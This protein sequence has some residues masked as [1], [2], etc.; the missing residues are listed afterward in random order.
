MK[1]HFAEHLHENVYDSQIDDASEAL[2]ILPT[3]TVSIKLRPVRTND[4]NE[5]ENAYA[6]G[7]DY[8]DFK[9][10]LKTKQSD[11]AD[12]DIDNNSAL[13]TTNDGNKIFY[14]EHES[15]PEFIFDV[16]MKAIEFVTV[17][18]GLIL[19][20]SELMKKNDDKRHKPETGKNRIEAISIEERK[21]GKKTKVTKIIRI[22]GVDKIDLTSTE[23]K[24]LLKKLK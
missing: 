16:T 15:G 19:I 6:S 10:Y 14:I 2:N 1:K 24:N 9:N 7:W 18:G 12:V 22:D 4:N 20:I 8:K 21:K 11:F 17:V 13:I 23:I 5:Y 3:D